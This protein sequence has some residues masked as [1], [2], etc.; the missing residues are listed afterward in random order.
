MRL[1]FIVLAV[2][3]IGCSQGSDSGHAPGHDSGT[4]L[5]AHPWDGPGQSV[6]DVAAIDQGPDR[7]L[8]V[9][10][11]SS[12]DQGAE[13][14]DGPDLRPELDLALEVGHASDEAGAD[15]A[16]TDGGCT[17]VDDI[18]VAQLPAIDFSNYHS[19]QQI[20][21]Y[22]RAVAAALPTLAQYR[23]LGQSVQG[24]DVAYLILNATCQAS[25]PALLA[26]GTHHGDEPSST[27][28]ALAIPDYLLRKSATD[29]SVRN[30]LQ[31]FAFYVLPLVNPDGHAD[32]SRGNADGV[33]INRDYSYP[34]RSDAYSFKTIEA[35]LI[36]GLQEAVGFRAA[37][38]YHSGAQ[39]VI[40]PWCYTGNATA[41]GNFFL[42]AGQ[43]AAA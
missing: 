24:R 13:P 12:L 41:D 26:N 35:R 31:G 4:D 11:G 3:A 22:L 21:D 15:S 25:P 30:L 40:W 34:G 18:V 29:P 28:A 38:A 39:E 2:S 23:V 1:R 10:T 42:A 37:V 33:D 19:Q 16:T 20:E 6:P 7:G 5:G 36:K 9:D 27:E 17:L 32:G 43:K 8:I 14:M